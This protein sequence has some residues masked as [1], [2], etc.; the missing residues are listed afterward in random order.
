MR[1]PNFYFT[2]SVMCI[3]IALFGAFGAFA[4]P[5]DRYAVQRKVKN[6]G[7]TDVFHAF[8]DAP[9]TVLTNIIPQA[10][11]ER[12]SGQ[13]LD[14]DGNVIPYEPIT[15]DKFAISHVTYSNRVILTLSARFGNCYRTRYTNKDDLKAWDYYLTPF[16]YGVTNAVGEHQWMTLE[17]RQT[18]LLEVKPLEDL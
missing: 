3:V 12:V 18:K 1:K 10:A 2:F 9:A 5:F 15:L 4:D 13:M 7:Y 16:G 17:E 8:V 6:I 11:R 14:E